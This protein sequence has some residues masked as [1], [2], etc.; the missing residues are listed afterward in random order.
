MVVANWLQGGDLTDYRTLA[1]AL[2]SAI[3]GYVA[4]DAGVSG[5]AK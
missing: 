3:L 2:V 1:M 5:T 4:K